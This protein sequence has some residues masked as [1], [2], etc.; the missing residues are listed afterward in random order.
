MQWGFITLHWHA[1]SSHQDGNWNPD[2]ISQLHTYAS[3]E[4]VSYLIHLVHVC[5]WCNIDQPSY[6]HP[7]EPTLYHHPK[8][9][10]IYRPIAIVIF[11]TVHTLAD[12][13]KKNDKV[14]AWC[15]ILCW[16]YDWLR[17]CCHYAWYHAAW[18]TVCRYVWCWLFP[19]IILMTILMHGCVMDTMVAVSANI[20]IFVLLPLSFPRILMPSNFKFYYFDNDGQKILQIIQQI[21]LHLVLM[22]KSHVNCYYQ[23]R[24][25]IITLIGKSP[26]Q[27]VM[28]CSKSREC[29]R[30]S[31]RE[32]RSGGWGVRM[33]LGEVC[34]WGG[35]GRY[36]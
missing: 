12:D 17:P 7:F 13:L 25:N 22:Q 32:V 6:F 18:H 20:Y 24:V 9:L 29:V 8:R 16:F 26:W 5:L 21:L 2:Q 4:W 36:R 28:D 30:W 35:M 15:I 11:M 23:G 1:A 27:L 31:E 19:E 14:G 34:R 10:C 3:N 33:M